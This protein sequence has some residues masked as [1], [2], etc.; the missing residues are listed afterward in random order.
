[1]PSE[2]PA[3]IFCLKNFHI[4]IMTNINKVSKILAEKIFSI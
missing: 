3:E 2:I 1:M 4:N